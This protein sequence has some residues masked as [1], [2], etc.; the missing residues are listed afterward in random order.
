MKKI[1]TLPLILCALM[2]LALL[3]MPQ[4]PAVQSRALAKADIILIDP[5]HGGIDGGAVG[6]GGICEKDLNLQ[7]AKELQKL[8]EADGWQVIMTRKEDCSLAEDLSAS[9]R[10][11]KTQDLHAR[12]E[13]IEK[14]EPLLAVSIHLN[15]FKEDPSVRGAQTFYSTG[16]GEAAVLERGKLLAEAIQAQ[17]ETGIP[18]EKDRAALG[19][20]DVFLLKKTTVPTV[21]VE[22]GFLSNLEEG[23]LLTQTDYQKKLAACIYAGILEYTGRKPTSPI[24]VLV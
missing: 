8:A 7:I 17:L 15:S 22:C 5:G 1:I 23:K 10:S 6:S 4:S 2:T 21:I 19:K 13:L 11:Q 24:K 3:V 9:I 16:Q 18:D 14:T 12:Q 20:N